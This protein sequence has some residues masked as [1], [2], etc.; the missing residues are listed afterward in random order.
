MIPRIVHRHYNAQTGVDQWETRRTRKILWNVHGDWCLISDE[1]AGTPQVV[2]RSVLD[3]SLPMLPARPIS[4][5]I[6]P[7]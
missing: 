2:H 4:D 3:L 7:P 6:P 5:L 1:A